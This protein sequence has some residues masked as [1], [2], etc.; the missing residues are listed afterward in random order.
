VTNGPIVLNVLIEA[1]PGRE[2]DVARELCALLA[3]TRCEAGCLAY[4]LHRDPENHG[5]FMFY[6]K[7]ANQIDLD[8][9]VNSS[10]FKKFQS[11]R[12]KSDPIAAQT[13]THWRTVDDLGS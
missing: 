9:H 1:V 12:E 10:Y 7:F 8:L 13:V 6:E 5:R 2:D 3:P 4:E 11:Y